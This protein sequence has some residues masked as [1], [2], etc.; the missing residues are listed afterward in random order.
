MSAIQG[1]SEIAFDRPLHI[2]G[3]DEV[4]FAIAIVIHP[5]CAG[6]KFIRPPQSSSLGHISEGAVAVV[7]EEMVLAGSGNEQIVVAVV[8]VVAYRNAKPK[9]WDIESG[10]V[11]H[12]G[13]CAVMVV[14]IKLEGSDRS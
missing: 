3:D 7:V 1:T 4:E 11:S 6:G 10:L 8:V 9:H 12:V 14:V 2:V 5:G 13:K